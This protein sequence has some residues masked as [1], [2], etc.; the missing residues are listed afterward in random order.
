MV[1]LDFLQVAAAV[2]DIRMTVMVVLEVMVGAVTEVLRVQQAVEAAV[3][4]GRTVRPRD[5]PT[6]LAVL[7]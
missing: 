6:G 1:N 7:E 5:T 4:A 3:A 2:V